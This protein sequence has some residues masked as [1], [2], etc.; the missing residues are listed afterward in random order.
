MIHGETKGHEG[1]GCWV[2]SAD[3][4]ARSRFTVSP[5]AE[6]VSALTVLSR[7]D[8]PRLPWARSLWVGHRDAYLAML[9]RDEVRAAV[10]GHLWRPRRGAV[11]GWIAEFLAFP[12]LG[13]GA[14]FDD[15][16][17]QFVMWDD[18]RIRAE[19][20]QFACG[21]LSAALGRPG[22]RDAATGILRW[23]WDTALAPDWRR[24]RRVL[25]ADIIARTSRL[26]V[27]G[28]AEAL[29]TLA[30]QTAWLGDGRL[31]IDGY[32]IPD[33]DLSH[34]R[35]LSFVPV[36]GDGTW[37]AWDL[38]HRYALVYPAA[39]VLAE[40]GSTDVGPDPLARL[41]GPN[42]ARVLRLLAEPCSTTQIA[43]LTGLLPGAV[44]GHLR[45]L[46]DADAVLRRRAGREVLYWRT[47]FGDSLAATGN[48]DGG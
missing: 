10:A 41:I 19:I 23:T 8:S 11:P 5:L 14:T 29:G 39:G 1:L 2:V 47:P 28:W 33:Q 45:V 7:S 48:P 32:D 27:G 16:I 21:P 3:L 36:H 34:V 13:D 18:N 31:Q 38:P 17:G 6:T 30:A 20:R 4:L 26:A 24:R 46:L 43:A 35:E 12:P 44:S 9:A 15:E 37:A 42:R 25:E 40:T 22:L